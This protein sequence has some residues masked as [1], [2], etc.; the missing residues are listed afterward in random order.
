MRRL[1]DIV[2][3]TKI[4]LQAYQI[5]RWLSQVSNGGIVGNKAVLICYNERHP[6]RSYMI[7]EDLPI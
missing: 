1:V 4:S 5:T 3:R 7:V 2:P 6:E